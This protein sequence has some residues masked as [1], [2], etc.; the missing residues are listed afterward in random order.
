MHLNKKKNEKVLSAINENLRQLI[1]LQKWST[2]NTVWYASYEL[3]YLCFIFCIENT[4]N[5][6]PEAKAL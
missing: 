5:S 1:I 6:E 2:F 4:L 3:F